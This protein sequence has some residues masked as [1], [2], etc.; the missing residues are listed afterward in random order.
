MGE[1][2]AP[3]MQHYW[4]I[5]DVRRLVNEKKLYGAVQVLGFY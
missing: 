3:P 1:L 4:N 2:E 5:E